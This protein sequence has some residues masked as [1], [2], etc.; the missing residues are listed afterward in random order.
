MEKEEIIYQGIRKTHD[1]HSLIPDNNGFAFKSL[2][3]AILFN[4]RSKKSI[5]SGAKYENILV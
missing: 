2:I 5:R 4:D 1:S 3:H